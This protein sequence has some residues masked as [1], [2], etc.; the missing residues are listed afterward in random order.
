MSQESLRKA[1]NELMSG[2][3]WKA[4]DPD[5][6]ILY[7][8]PA[9]FPWDTLSP[10]KYKYKTGSSGPFSGNCVEQSKYIKEHIPEFKMLYRRE[11]SPFPNA[12]H[13][14]PV[15]KHEDGWRAVHL[16][17][18]ID[19]NGEDNYL[20]TNGRN[21]F[22]ELLLSQIPKDHRKDQGFDFYL[23]DDIPNKGDFLKLHQYA[24]KHGDRLKVRDGKLLTT[25]KYKS[26]FKKLVK[27]FKDLYGIDLSNL[28]YD[29]D[30]KARNNLGD[31][32]DMP[33]EE[34]GGYWMKD[35]TITI[36]P[37]IKKVMKHYGVTSPAKDYINAIIAHE[38]SHDV[39]HNPKYRSL[40]KKLVAEAK[41]K[42]F[43]TP[44]LKTVPEHKIDSETFAE[45]LAHL[46]NTADTK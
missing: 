35:H 29:N 21:T 12:I 33:E 27:K 38:M 15:I 20:T 26:N 24:Q 16:K 37:K 11:A 40:V 5:S 23:L 18:R 45:Y 30:T 25:T 43:T 31:Y 9:D 4:I 28:K 6:G 8:E 42:K 36:N 22:E 10:I 32:V 1:I 46:I 13:I 44:Y 7:T 14:S 2:Y 19:D 41:K 34:L 39:E 3:R 17:P